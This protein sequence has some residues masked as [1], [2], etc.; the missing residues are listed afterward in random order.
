MG[1]ILRFIVLEHLAHQAGRHFDLRWEN[2]NG[3]GWD[4]FAVPMGVPL[5]R[6]KKV[7]CIKT[8]QHSEKDALFTGRIPNGSYGAGTLKKYDDGDCVIEKYTDKHIVID[9][10][11]N[12][13]TGVYHLI[14]IQDTGPRGK[15]RKQK[16]YILFKGALKTE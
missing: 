16:Q 13:I 4:S 6:G 7:L 2:P 9:F 14:R 1:K 5:N 10:K 15:L 3:N 12:K 8:N 11:G